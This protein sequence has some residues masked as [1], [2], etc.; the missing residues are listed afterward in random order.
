MTASF[1][2]ILAPVTPA[3]FFG[4]YHGRTPLHVPG[5]AN[6]FSNV[7]TRA[8]LDELIAVPGL[9]TG[10][11][12]QMARDSAMVPAGDYL[13][14]SGAADAAKVRALLG[15]GASLVLNDIDMAAP[16]LASVAA[17]ARVLENAL[18]A[19]VQ[20]NLYSSPRERRAFASHYDTHDVFAVHVEGEKLWRVYEGRID[21]PIEHPTF[22]SQTR[23]FHEQAKGKVAL[24]VLMKPGDLLYLPRG[25]YH[26]A[27]A[28]SERTIHI[29]FGAVGVIGLDVV[30]ALFAR[31]VDDPLFRADLPRR[32][33]QEP[34]AGEAAF[35]ARLQALGKRLADLASDPA[36][37]AALQTFQDGFRYRTAQQRYR[38]TAGDFKVVAQGGGWVLA[39]AGKG[40]PIPPGVDRAVAWAIG[41]SDFADS[42]LA[43]A[44]PALGDS[45]RGELLRSLVAMKVIVTV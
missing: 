2:E 9:W 31:A 11:S 44:F 23:A 35:A 18:E 30:S 17:V 7:M 20:A 28:L 16:G 29:A 14:A 25:Q 15:S 42:D 3:E 27:V 41:Q 10:Q 38:V 26:D 39:R 34:G 40:T 4:T 37:L 32:H 33:G 24:E 12:L 19:K 22:K 43:R 13:S 45:A 36:S 21:N 1:A 6:K 8:K 5:G